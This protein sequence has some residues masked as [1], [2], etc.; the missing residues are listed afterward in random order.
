MEPAMEVEL[1]T[2]WVWTVWYRWDDGETEAML[3]V[4]LT[5][6]V[7]IKEAH[8]SLSSAGEDYSILG[9]IRQDD[10]K[11]RELPALV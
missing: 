9:L 8:Y 10:T 6:E 7:A 11:A 3:V 4:A 2:G 5:V 1:A